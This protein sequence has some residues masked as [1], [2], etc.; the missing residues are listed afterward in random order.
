MK[1]MLKF[2][3]LLLSLAVSVQAPSAVA[4]ESDRAAQV[5]KSND[6]DGDGKLSRDE[7]P[8]RPPMFKRLDADGD[9]YLSIEELRVR[10]GGGQGAGS[11]PAMPDGRTT[12][13]A[14]DGET[15]CA[16][17]RFQKCD[18]KL[19]VKRGLFPTG[20]KPA[21]PQGLECR[22]I[23]DETYAKDYTVV[24]GK[25]NYHGG[26]DMPAPFGTPMLAAA[27]GT[28]VAV[29]SGENT[30]RGIEVIIRHTPED[31]GIPLWIYTQ[32]THFHG[33]TNVRVGQRVRM[34]EP[35][36]PTGNSGIMAPGLA[37][38]KG[39]RMGKERRPA[40][41]FGAW[42]SAKPEYVALQQRLIPVD[43]HWM[44]PNALY[45][46]RP[47]FDSHA[48]KALPPEEKKVPVSV[49]LEDGTTVPPDTK[50]IWPY[51][52]KRR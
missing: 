16:I 40:I 23:D 41:H 10:F 18:I 9:G 36:G 19:A 4:Q 32:Y 6:G 43:G 42:F 48:M 45:R 39:A 21:F 15:F 33:T 13:D 50:I 31:T 29:F 5:L 38:R 26:I 37:N 46:K 11:G 47:P 30:M 49:I 20:L 44:D 35:L 2:A 8:F 25:E 22:D 3:L 51:A 1:A 28:V 24:A 12:R 27:A 14:L 7:W 52:C 17:A 34:G